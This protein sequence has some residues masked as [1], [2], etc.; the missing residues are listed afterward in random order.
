MSNTNSNMFIPQAERTG[1]PKE[2]F[3]I[4][5]A[6]NIGIL[7]VVYGALIVGYRLSFI[8]S[9]L[10]AIIGALSFALV[11]YLSLSG[12]RSGGTTFVLSRAVFGIRGNLIPNLLGWLSL[13]GWLAVNVVTGT[14]TLLSL[15]GLL[16]FEQSAVWTV[17]S[18]AIFVLLILTSNLFG[19]D[20]LVKIQTFFTYVFGALTFLILIILIPKTDWTALL[21]MPDGGWLSSF[22]PAISIIIA[23]TGISW[24]IA[25][26]DYSAY[27]NPGNTG[28]K[29]FASVTL[30]AFIPLFFIMGVGILLSTSVPDL[31]S[32]ANP[33]QAIGQALPTWMTVL[34]F[35]TALGGLIPQCIISLKSARVNLETLNIRVSD[36]TAIGIH[37]VIMILIPVYVLFVS[38]DFLMNFQLFLGLLGIGLAAWAAVFMFDYMLLRSKSGYEAR[39]LDN[40]TGRSFE[41]RGVISWLAGV[42]V[43]FL[44]TNSPFFSGPFAKGIFQDNS[45][46]VLLAFVASALVMTV[47]TKTNSKSA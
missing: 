26:A 14:L 44:F 16:G 8:Q 40:A 5:F 19:Q 6:S 13:I 2:L 33:I 42:V 31:A 23:G 37:A 25:A 1:S 29:V 28:G 3:F 15:L 35:I 18:L 10:S 32:A 34:Y 27:Q 4:W 39:L 7:G 24:S 43:G 11:G 20:M 22:L 47:L 41:Y 17:I 9:V 38:E 30:G 46:G 21:S 45:L 36:R 12:L